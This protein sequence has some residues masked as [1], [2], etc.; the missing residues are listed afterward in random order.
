M[1]WGQKHDSDWIF[2]GFFQK[3]KYTYQFVCTQKFVCSCEFGED[4]LDMVSDSR[5][6]YSSVSLTASKRNSKHLFREVIVNVWDLLSEMLPQF[7]LPSHFSAHN[8]TCIFIPSQNK[9]IKCMPSSYKKMVREFSR[10]IIS[11]LCFRGI[12]KKG[13]RIC[14]QWSWKQTVLRGSCIQNLPQFSLCV[15]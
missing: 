3:P 15:A 11:L 13:I 10:L 4:I 8:N 12:N 7:C 5:V 2:S 6:D 14:F 1:I 9:F